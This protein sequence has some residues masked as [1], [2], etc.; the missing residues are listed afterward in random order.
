MARFQV[1]VQPR[2][3]GNEIAGREGDAIK[4]RLTAP[5]VD[6]KANKALIDFL[7]ERL[8]VSKSALAIVAGQSARNKVIEVVG[9]SEA[10]VARR[11]GIGPDRQ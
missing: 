8:G 11:L 5:P 6:G 2:A 7:A 10:E 3:S 4:V 9:L 1:R